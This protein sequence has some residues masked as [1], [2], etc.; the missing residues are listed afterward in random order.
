MRL[1]TFR[2]G[3]GIRLGVERDGRLVDL[4]PAATLTGAD[5]PVGATADMLTLISGGAET[6]GQIAALVEIAPTGTLLT[7]DE[8]DLL[9]PIPRPRKNIFCVG[10]NYAE[11]AAESMRAVG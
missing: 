9:A 3:A 8:V 1:A 5:L 2:D 6:L 10:R 7:L 4:S 11:H